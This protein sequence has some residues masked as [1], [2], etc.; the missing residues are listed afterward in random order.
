MRFVETPLFTEA[1]VTLMPDDE[2]ASFQAALITRPDLGAVLPGGGGVRKVRW[3][4]PGRGKRGGARVIYF[5][6]PIPEVCFMLYAYRK[7][8][9][10]DLTQ[11]QIRLLKRLVEQEFK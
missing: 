3:G 4:L 11:A 2:Y 5:W 6:E 10:Q 7:S 1:I 9:A 8:E